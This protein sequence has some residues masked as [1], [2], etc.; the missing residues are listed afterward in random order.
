MTLR[1]IFIHYF[2]AVRI[3]IVVIKQPNK[4]ELILLSIVW[5]AHVVIKVKK[6]GPLPASDSSWHFNP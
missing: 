6:Q 1:N 2:K 5:G 4:G 3:T